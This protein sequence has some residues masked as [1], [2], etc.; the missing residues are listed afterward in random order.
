MNKNKT[1]LYTLLLTPP[2]TGLAVEA[3]F[4][5]NKGLWAASLPLFM[6][7]IFIIFLLWLAAIIT[8]MLIHMDTHRRPGKIWQGKEFIMS[9]ALSLCLAAIIIYAFHP[10]FTLYVTP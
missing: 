4:I 7:N 5:L 2:F 10:H 1:I 8:G 3:A 6:L 9:A